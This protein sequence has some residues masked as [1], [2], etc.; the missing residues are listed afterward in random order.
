VTLIYGFGDASGEGFG[1]A[2]G[3]L[4]NTSG[5]NNIRVRRGF[6]CSAISEEASNYREFHNLLDAVEDM[7][8]VGNL[9]GAE[10]YLFTDNSTSEAIYYTGSTDSPKLFD[11]MLDLKT[12]ALQVGFN[13]YLIHIAGT[14]MIAQG[15]DG[16]SRGELQLGALFDD[17][18]QSVPLHLDPV[19]RTEG[20]L[21]AWVYDWT[22][23]TSS[24]LRLAG[25]MDWMYN[26][27]M[28]GTWIWSLP[29]AAALY[30]LEELA[31]ARLK[32]GEH[33]GAIVLIPSLMKPEW[34]RRFA[35]IVD[36]YF[37]VPV[38]HPCWP[39]SMHESL[40]VGIVFPILRHEPW[41]WRRVPFMVGL[42][43]TLSVMHKADHH[44]AG[45]LLRK[46]W[47]AHS[48]AVHLPAGVVRPLLH[49]PNYHPFL[50]LSEQGRRRER[51]SG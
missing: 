40:M 25:P 13:L 6:W 32:R 44:E 5:D 37:S 45:N 33:V 50:S 49:D 47:S 27:H 51:A 20:G 28:P 11:L 3:V 31:F 4:G 29:P 18:T 23:M 42:G 7:A 1:S 39:Q 10:I 16:L 2:V 43:R 22:G 41:H 17:S 9:E 24:S 46:F 36:L 26:A 21:A 35:R 12:L 34:F 19:T 14:R 8:R 15:T 30:A 38:G 48:R